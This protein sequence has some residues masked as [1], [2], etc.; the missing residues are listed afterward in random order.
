ML[1]SLMNQGSGT[2]VEWKGRISV[3]MTMD[4]FEPSPH[5]PDLSL[6]FFLLEA[7]VRIFIKFCVCYDFDGLRLDWINISLGKANLSRLSVLTLECKK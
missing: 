6:E 2:E 1:Y 4:M 5:W 7:C 3:H